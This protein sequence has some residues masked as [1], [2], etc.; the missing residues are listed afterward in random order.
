MKKRLAFVSKECVACGVCMKTCPLGAIKVEN[1][2]FAE[3]DAKKCAGC[4][5]CEKNCPAQVI[6]MIERGGANEKEVV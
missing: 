5:K 3:V 6:E 2:V 1:G 4:A